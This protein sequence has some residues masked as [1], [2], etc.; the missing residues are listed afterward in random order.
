MKT[1]LTNPKMIVLFVIEG[2]VLLL[3]I[4]NLFREKQEIYIE[5]QEQQVNAG[6]YDA[7]YNTVTG[8]AFEIAFYGMWYWQL[9][10]H[11]C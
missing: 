10:M 5:S 4:A 3:C 1:I 6:T 9:A 8:E 2:I 7:A 11:S